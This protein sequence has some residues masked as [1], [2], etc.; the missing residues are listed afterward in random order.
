[1]G[2]KANNPQNEPNAMG[3]KRSISNA[4][5]YI[6]WRTSPY[7][8]VDF[9]FCPSPTSITLEAKLFSLKTRK[10]VKSP[11]TTKCPLTKRDILELGTI[12]NDDQKAE[13]RLAK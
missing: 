4:P 5:E 12:G 7:G 2:I 9:T 1:M 11:S 6:G 13:L 8:P 3:V 10:S